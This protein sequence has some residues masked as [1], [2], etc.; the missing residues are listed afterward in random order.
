MTTRLLLLLPLFAGLP[1][2]LTGALRPPA[3][4]P[5][6][7]FVAQP[8]ALAP[9]LEAAKLTVGAVL[10]RTIERLSPARLRWLKVDLWQRTRDGERAFESLGTLQLGPNHCARLDL[11]IRTGS[12][13]GQWLVVSD[14][15]ALAHVVQLGS[16]PP[17]VDSRLLAPAPDSKRSP[18]D[19]L[20]EHGCG[21]PY[22][23]LRDLR[24]RCQDVAMQTGRLQ[25]RDWVRI[26]G[27]LAAAPTASEPVAAALAD[28]CYLYLDAQTLW[29]GRV[30]W[31]ARG[32][33]PRLLLEMEFRDPQVNRELSLD[34]CIR[35]FSYRP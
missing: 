30:E 11:T 18:G 31:W 28:F 1:L 21:G 17:T 13:T 8:V 6:P 12:M 25:N 5:A 27:R 16:D 34:E 14:G 2:F 22:P 7:A 9:E 35:A 10:D 29:P 24:A 4:D 32:T 15:H 3:A 23:L 26:K 20:R 19:V 33:T